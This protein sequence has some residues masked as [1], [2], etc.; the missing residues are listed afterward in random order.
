VLF[1]VIVTFRVPGNGE[2]LVRPNQ[3]DSQFKRDWKNECGADIDIL[4][5]ENNHLQASLGQPPIESEPFT[6]DCSIKQ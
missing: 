1:K 2:V 5:Q 3:P 4:L 6:R